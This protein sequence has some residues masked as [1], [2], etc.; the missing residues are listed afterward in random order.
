MKP[1]GPGRKPEETRVGRGLG[2]SEKLTGVP[3]VPLVKN[4]NPETGTLFTAI[5]WFT[6]YLR[7]LGMGNAAVTIPGHHL[8]LKRQREV[9][10]LKFARWKQKLHCSMVQTPSL[11]ATFW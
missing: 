1:P 9:V 11:P 8:S 4:K 7:L 2:T 10:Y 6:C 3:H 5:S